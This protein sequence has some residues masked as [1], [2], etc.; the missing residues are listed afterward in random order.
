MTACCEMR[1][2]KA[3]MPLD[4]RVSL[5][6]RS[7]DLNDDRTWEDKYCADPEFGSDDSYHV[8]HC[9]RCCAQMR[10]ESSCLRMQLPGWQWTGPVVVICR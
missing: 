9:C 3:V 2:I 4:W 5:T 7:G 6:T 8:S 10:H 1:R